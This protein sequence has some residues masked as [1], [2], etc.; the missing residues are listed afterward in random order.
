MLM[1]GLCVVHS[2]WVVRI[3]LLPPHSELGLCVK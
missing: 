2:E 3:L 1:L